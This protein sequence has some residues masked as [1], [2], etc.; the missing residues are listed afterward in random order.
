MSARWQQVKE[1]FQSALDLEAS[2]RAAFLEKNCHDAALRNEVLSL[3]ENHDNASNFLESPI[4]GPAAQLLEK[5]NGSIG[6][7][8][9]KATVAQLNSL[10][11]RTL[12]GQYQIESLLGH[13]GMG[14]V[15]RARHT[16]LDNYV[17]IK[18][19]SPQISN[20]AKYRQ[21][22]LRE[23]KAATL[24]RHPNAVT[25][26]DLRETEGGLIYL[27]LDYID[28]HTLSDELKKR[29]RFSAVEA[30]EILA[31]IASALNA[32]HA[33]GVIHCDLKPGNIMLGNQSPCQPMLLDLG[34]ARLPGQQHRANTSASSIAGLSRDLGTPHYMSPEQWQKLPD[35]DGRADIYSLAI[36]FYELIAGHKPFQDD[37]KKSLAEQ[38]QNDLAPSLHEVTNDTPMPFSRVIARAMAKDR[39]ERP[40]TC[41]E[42]IEQL[43]MSLQP[44]K[45][46]KNIRYAAVLA[47]I[48]FIVAMA[49]YPAYKKRAAEPTILIAPPTVDS[50]NNKTLSA[51]EPAKPIETKPENEVGYSPAASAFN[52]WQTPV[53]YWEGKGSAVETLVKDDKKELHWSVDFIFWFNLDKDG[54]V[55]GEADLTYDAEMTVSGATIKPELRKSTDLTPRR[56]YPLVGMLIEKELT[57]DIGLSEEKREP[58]RFV[59]RADPNITGGSLIMEKIDKPPFSPFREAAALEKDPQSPYY[60]NY[61]LKNQQYDI[62][63]QARQIGDKKTAAH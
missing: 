15:Y 30:M 7:A 13:G 48:I 20:D 50:A 60:I 39:T 61:E 16:L 53:G 18:I 55:R 58:I 41:Q 19:M 62:N 40:A 57:L 63:W 36:I 8:D 51:H 26:H 6:S 25:V 9:D 52:R 56:H 5:D 14:A 45:K 44:V 49:F 33:R 38:H 46:A 27:V 3:L 35:I 24:F 43:Q 4:A 23:G 22:F 37:G 12:D 2:Q 1:L 11:G 54:N 28:G 21:L 42:F 47:I 17:A 59:L 32:A 29:G 34:T 31:P 10:I